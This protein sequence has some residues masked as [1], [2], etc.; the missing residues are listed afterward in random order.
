M[1]LFDL[2]TQFHI[3]KAV[4]TIYIKTPFILTNHYVIEQYMCPSVG[5]SSNIKICKDRPYITG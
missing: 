4:N 3:D 2:S 1:V 5:L